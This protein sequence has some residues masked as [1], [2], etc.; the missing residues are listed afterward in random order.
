MPNKNMFRIPSVFYHGKSYNLITFGV[1]AALASMAGYYIAFF[2]LYCNGVQIGNYAWIIILF[3]VLPNLIFAKIFSIFSMGL[4]KFYKNLRHHLNETS[5]YHQGGVF[6][7]IL[8][9]VCLF[10]ILRIPFFL[11]SDAICFGGL[12]TMFIG[13][14]GCYNYGCCVGKPTQQ[15]YGTVYSDPEAKICREVPEFYGIP[16]I[17]VQLIASG[18]DLLLFCLCFIVIFNYPYSGIITIIF[19]VGLNLKRIIIQPWRWKD[20]SN[21]ISYQWAAVTLILTFVFIVFFLYISGE[22]LFVKEKLKISQNSVNN[23]TYILTDP[24]LIL[25]ILTG[26]IINFIA[27]GIHGKK[28]GTYFNIDP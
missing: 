11:L 5:F 12:A 18:I 23:L 6:G 21:K 8:S 17:P 27:Y 25:P 10:Y 14:L 28:L 16:L 24:K 4:K 15:K 2:Y 7:F 19:I 9:A 3:F 1:F 22:M 13:R 26:G 20:P